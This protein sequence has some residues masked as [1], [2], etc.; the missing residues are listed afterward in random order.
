MIRRKLSEIEDDEVRFII[1]HFTPYKTDDIIEIDRHELRGE[2]M[3]N[4]KMRMRDREGNLLPGAEGNFVMLRAE[5]IFFSCPV[6]GS[7]LDF[8]SEQ[9]INYLKSQNFN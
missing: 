4:V 7:C 3:V 9:A 2:D 6:I 5:R 1:E 8:D